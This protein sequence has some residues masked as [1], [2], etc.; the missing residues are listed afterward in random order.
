MFEL[1]SSK[2]WKFLAL[3][4]IVTAAV[5]FKRTYDDYNIFTIICPQQMNNFLCMLRIMSTMHG[6]PVSNNFIYQ[7]INMSLEEILRWALQFIDVLKYLQP[8]DCRISPYY[9]FN[10]TLYM[11]PLRCHFIIYFAI[12]GVQLIYLFIKFSIVFYLNFCFSLVF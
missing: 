10:R 3:Y 5:A 7:I 2:M 11:L 4:S 6:V 1:K 9:E 12:R 8:V